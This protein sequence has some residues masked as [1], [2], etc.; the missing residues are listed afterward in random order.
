VKNSRLKF[1]IFLSPVLLALAA[2]CVDINDARVQVQ[3][4]GQ[5]DP[6]SR[7][8][9]DQ[10][11]PVVYPH[12]L[13]VAKTGSASP[14]AQ[15]GP[16]M[17]YNQLDFDKYW[18]YV[19]AQDS[20][21]ISTSNLSQVPLVNWDQQWAYFL[22]V[23]ANNSCE[24]TKPFGEEMKTDCYTI[25]IPLYRYQ[26]GTDCQ[27][28]TSF[29]VFIYLFPKTNLPVNFVWVYPTPIP[30]ATPK[31]TLTSTPTATPTPPP[32]SEDE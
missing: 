20:D 13:I 28:P 16:Q 22:V 11:T 14:L 17:V 30:T 4:P 9:L 10:C 32:D 29:T 24:K 1:F 25:S 3:A 18:G 7:I 2:G 12:R 15:V 5:V 31:P 23:G 21:K 27:P 6:Y 26:E 8:A 19:T